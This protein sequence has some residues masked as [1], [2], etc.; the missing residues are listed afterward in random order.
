MSEADQPTGR[1]AAARVAFVSYASADRA[2]AEALTA[3]LEQRGRTCW[4]APRDVPAGAQ[5]ADAI[6]R[7]INEARALVLILSK[8]SINSSHVGKEVERASSK[9]KQII[10]V[11]LD[12][13]PLTP[14][15]EYFLSESQWV[16]VAADGR[17]K[18]FA[19]L[20][21]A[22]TQGSGAPGS[23]AVTVAAPAQRPRAPL[24]LTA[25]AAVAVVAAVAYFA[26]RP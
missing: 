10:A 7:A 5:Y 12:G 20:A 17:E 26:L 6:V 2:V 24:A 14:A 11:R 22:L 23:G 13:A 25:V 15:L 21:E 16:D 1:P 9:K 4:M 3:H 18:A 19:K 8:E